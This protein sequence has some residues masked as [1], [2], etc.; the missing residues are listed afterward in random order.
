MVEAAA[1][2]QGNLIAA[3]S[4]LEGLRQ[5]YTDGNVRVRAVRARIEEL[6]KKLKQMGG[7]G[8]DSALPQ[9]DNDSLYPSIR[10]LPLLGV[11]YYDLYRRTVIQETVFELLTQQCELA[12]VQEAKET[13][14]VKI[15]DVATVPE[16]KSFP[17]RLLIMLLGTFLSFVF[18]TLWIIA[19][20]GWENMDPQSPG[21]MLAH[22]TYAK[23]RADMGLTSGNGT[24]IRHMRDKILW[25]QRP[26]K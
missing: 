22:E 10:Q 25:F 24:R 8:P 5:V 18:G 20:A 23:I 7:A 4:E 12:K 21:K 3:Q 9:K 16:R 1:S 19:R 2:L 14:S 15:L 6:Q 17:P 13:P 11:T 26:P